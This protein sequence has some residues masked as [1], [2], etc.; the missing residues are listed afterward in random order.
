MFNS[1]IELHVILGH[2]GDGATRST[3]ARSSTHP[4]KHHNKA[5]QNKKNI[6]RG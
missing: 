4:S 5:G 1:L 2:K 3:S 6:H